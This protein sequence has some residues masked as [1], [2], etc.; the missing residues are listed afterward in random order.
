MIHQSPIMLDLAGKAQDW[1]KTPLD[2]GS[3]H[4]LDDLLFRD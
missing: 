4:Y 3:V 1:I 2:F